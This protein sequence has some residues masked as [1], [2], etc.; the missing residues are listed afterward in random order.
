[1]SA[2]SSLA[3]GGW[4]LPSPP[5][6]YSHR[7]MD[8]NS[9]GHDQRGTIPNCAALRDFLW[10]VFKIDLMGHRLDTASSP[11]LCDSGIEREL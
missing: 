4:S 1:M 10:E 2:R 3:L 5:H 11:S 8:F 9:F 7:S 6:I